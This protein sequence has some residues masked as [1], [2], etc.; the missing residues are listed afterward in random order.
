MIELS[1]IVLDGHI[2]QFGTAV[3]FGQS[4]IVVIQVEDDEKGFHFGCHGLFLFVRL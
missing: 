4:E 3:Q 1:G 2:E